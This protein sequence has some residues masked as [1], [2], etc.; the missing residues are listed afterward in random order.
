MLSIVIHELP[1]QGEET[2]ARLRFEHSR[3]KLARPATFRLHPLRW[4]LDSSQQLDQG[5]AEK[6][7]QLLSTFNSCY[8]IWNY[9]H[10]SHERE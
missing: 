9:C 3:H 4:T 7:C 5:T 8:Y 2:L 10:E 6:E 1:L